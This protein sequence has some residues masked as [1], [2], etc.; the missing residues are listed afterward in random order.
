MANKIEFSD[1]HGPYEPHLGRE[2]GSSPHRHASTTSL[3]SVHLSSD[4][5]GGTRS[6]AEVN[7]IYFS[8][9]GEQEDGPKGADSNGDETALLNER[10]QNAVKLILLDE[11]LKLKTGNTIPD[12]PSVLQA[13]IQDQ[14]K[15]E[16]EVVRKECRGWS[17]KVRSVRSF[18]A[19]VLTY[20]KT[21]LEKLWDIVVGVVLISTFALAVYNTTQQHKANDIAQQSANFANQSV[22]IANQSAQTASSAFQLAR[23]GNNLSAVAASNQ[24]LADLFNIYTFCEA[25]PAARFQNGSTCQDVIGSPLA[26]PSFQP[27][28]SV[29]ATPGPISGGLSHTNTT[30]IV[31]SVVVVVAVLFGIFLTWRCCR[32]RR[33][34]VV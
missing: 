26:N 24:A 27:V 1:R 15:R 28:P 29:G 33:E 2:I 5:A 32:R 9:G 31:V 18:A 10:I 22:A 12:A 23:Q 8:V 13:A 17:N 20:S 21:I 6:T 30:A 14:V 3:P 34:G 11:L 19:L 4:N 7:S 25:Y 16:V